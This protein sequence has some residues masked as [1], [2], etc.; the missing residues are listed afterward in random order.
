MSEGK[1]KKSKSAGSTSGSPKPKGLRPKLFALI[2]RDE[3]QGCV[4]ALSP[5][6]ARS[7]GEIVL[8]GSGGR[9]LASSIGATIYPVAV[10]SVGDRL[11]DVLESQEDEAAGEVVQRFLAEALKAVLLQVVGLKPEGFPS[12]TTWL[13]TQLPTEELGR[14]FPLDEVFVMW[15]GRMLATAPTLAAFEAAYSRCEAP[16][17]TAF[18]LDTRIPRELDT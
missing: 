12:F 13:E 10:T 14:Q 1:T 7:K 11:R 15:E 8:G 16:P 5:R 2:V 3:L 18:S 9:S 4:W 17:L 6:E